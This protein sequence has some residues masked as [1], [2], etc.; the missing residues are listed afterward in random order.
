M[1]D[2]VAT[3]V[4]SNRKLTTWSSNET[5]YFQNSSGAALFSKCAN[6]EELH[7]RQCILSNPENCLEEIALG[8]LNLK[9]LNISHWTRLNAQM[10]LPI[11]FFSK[12]LAYLNTGSTTSITENICIKILAQM[13]N[14]KFLGISY[15]GIPAKKVS[16]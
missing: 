3:V 8:C 6:L 4:N 15:C 11:I 14:L 13:P 9:I 2:I 5:G 16:T 10:L 7:L 12:K 1:D